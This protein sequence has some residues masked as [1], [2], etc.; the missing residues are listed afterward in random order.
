MQPKVNVLSTLVISQRELSFFYI[1]GLFCFIYSRKRSAFTFWQK[2]EF[3][4]VF[5]KVKK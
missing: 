4:M 5:E 2:E 1:E 3:K